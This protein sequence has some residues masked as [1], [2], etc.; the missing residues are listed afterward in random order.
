MF[1]GESGYLWWLTD[2]VTDN[3]GGM[4]SYLT[5]DNPCIACGHNPP[6]ALTE[7]EAAAAMKGVVGTSMP[8]SFADTST[9]YDAWKARFLA[10][11]DTAGSDPVTG[12]ECTNGES[13]ISGS[14]S[15]LTNAPSGVNCSCSNQTDHA[16]NQLWQLDHDDDSSTPDRCVG[17]A[18]STEYIN[19]RIP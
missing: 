2:A 16:G 9:I 10:Q 11:E 17:I 4:A 7:D 18:F 13:T 3:F 15:K 5:D 8:S 6:A 14:T 12:G 1:G 19:G